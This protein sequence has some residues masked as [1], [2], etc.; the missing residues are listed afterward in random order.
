[1]S[2]LKALK[3]MV[4]L[5]G[6]A[7]YTVCFF[8]MQRSNSLCQKL[9]NVSVK[10]P[11]IV[12]AASTIWSLPFCCGLERAI[13]FV[14]KII[15]RVFISIILL[16]DLLRINHNQTILNILLSF[17]G[18][19][20]RLRKFDKNFVD[21]KT[22]RKKISRTIA[23]FTLAYLLYSVPFALMLMDKHTK[24]FC[25]YI[26]YYFYLYSIIN[27]CFL[28]VI[29]EQIRKRFVALNDQIRAVIFLSRGIFPSKNRFNLTLHSSMDGDMKGYSRIHMDLCA[30]SLKVNRQFQFQILLKTMHCTV[31]V[32][33]SIFY[34]LNSSEELIVVDEL[35]HLI[36]S[37]GVCLG[38]ALEIVI[39]FIGF[40]LV[41]KEVS[42]FIS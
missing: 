32:I 7:G 40:I 19:D 15:N 13:L 6:F 31:N 22:T 18:L 37:M 23:Y 39:M 11:L 29:L 12:F 27:E 2:L 3:P 28:L 21:Y 10:V 1:M 17:A 35:F 36:I 30:V 20:A 16:R 4:L 5:S 38:N 34:L 14:N 8:Y 33:F 26:Y 25:I 24:K 42:C 9:L 41:T